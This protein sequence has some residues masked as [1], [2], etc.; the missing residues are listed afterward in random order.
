MFF[1]RGVGCSALAVRDGKNRG[2]RLGVLVPVPVV[3]LPRQRQRP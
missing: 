1:L 3:V 2:A